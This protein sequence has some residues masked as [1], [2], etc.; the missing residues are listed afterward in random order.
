MSEPTDEQL[1]EFC[2]G[3]LGQPYYPDCMRNVGPRG[4]PLTDLNAA[5]RVAVEWKAQEPHHR[6]AG[7]VIGRMAWAKSVIVGDAE[8]L[9]E[10]PCN[11]PESMARGLVTT[12]WRAS[13]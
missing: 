1:I 11:T 5:V 3:V 9:H 10:Q 6:E 4:N 8:G 12:C 13:Q 2:L 7:I